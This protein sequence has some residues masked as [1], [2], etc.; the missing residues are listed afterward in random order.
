MEVHECLMFADDHREE[1]AQ[2]MDI[3]IKQGWYL[4]DGRGTWQGVL[5]E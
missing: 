4:K 2:Y 5:C 1:I 3:G